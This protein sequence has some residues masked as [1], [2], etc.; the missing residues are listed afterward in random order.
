[1]DAAAHHRL[2]RRQAVH[3]KHIVSKQAPVL[4]G[5]RNGRGMVLMRGWPDDL[6]GRDIARR[7]LYSDAA[8]IRSGMGYVGGRP[9]FFGLGG[10]MLAS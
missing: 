1:M 4:G 8:P 2:E 5:V 9:F 10:F 6:H 7:A 3:Q